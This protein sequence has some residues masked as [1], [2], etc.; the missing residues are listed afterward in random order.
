MRFFKYYRSLKTMVLNR[1]NL[2][3]SLVIGILVYI[4]SQKMFSNNNTTTLGPG[5]IL[6]I[7]LIVTS[8]FAY[9]I[10]F[11]SNNHIIQFPFTVKERTRYEYL[12]IIY[13]VI[14]AM[15]FFIFFVLVVLGLIALIGEIDITDGEEVDVNHWKDLYQLIHYIFIVSLFMPFSYIRES[16]KKYIYAIGILLAYTL[17]HLVIYKIASGHFMYNTLITDEVIK[18]QGHQILITI[19]LLLS[20]ASIYGSYRFSLHLKQYK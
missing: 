13:T 7:A 10:R 11:N 16:V 6:I 8:L 14:T 17:V 15:L 19:M 2:M 12:M 4:L 9:Q 1:Q 5:L 20:V 18:I 3:F